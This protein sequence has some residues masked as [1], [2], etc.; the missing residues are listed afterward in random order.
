MQKCTTTILLYAPL[1]SLL[2][3]VLYTLYLCIFF[4]LRIGL[5]LIQVQQ[6]PV[7][8]LCQ[9]HKII[10]VNGMF[11]GPTL[12]VRNG[13]SLVVNVVNRAKYNVTIHW[14]IHTHA[15]ANIYIHTEIYTHSGLDARM[16]DVLLW[17]CSLRS[18]ME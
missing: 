2:P 14:Y 1:S 6:T 17:F 16:H 9:T 11:P 4:V 7:K 3:F 12:K 15:H 18:G 8:R 10:T 5:D 13:D